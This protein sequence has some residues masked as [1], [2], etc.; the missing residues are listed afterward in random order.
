MA[1]CTNLNKVHL[2][3][4]PDLEVIES[5]DLEEDIM[6]MGKGVAKNDKNE[7]IMQLIIGY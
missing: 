3:Q 2:L 4:L 6:V 1:Y 7:E 5:L